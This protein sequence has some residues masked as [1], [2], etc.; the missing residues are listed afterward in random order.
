MGGIC[1]AEVGRVGERRGHGGR[2]ILLAGMLCRQRGR[3]GGGA[4]EVGYQAS[5]VSN[6]GKGDHHTSRSFDGTVGLETGY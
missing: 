2:G 4:G 3:G 1:V 5:V 6:V